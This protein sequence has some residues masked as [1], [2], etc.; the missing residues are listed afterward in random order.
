MYLHIQRTIRRCLVF[1]E[2]AIQFSTVIGQEGNVNLPSKIT[3]SE[4]TKTGVIVFSLEPGNYALVNAFPEITTNAFSYSERT[5]EVTVKDSSLLDYEGY[6]KSFVMRFEERITEG[7]PVGGDLVL[8]IELQDVQETSDSS[9][10]CSDVSTIKW[11][12]PVCSGIEL[13]TVIIWT[14]ILLVCLIKKK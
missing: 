9:S 7:N 12:V 8:L 14:T 10:C 2:F 3:V 5:G 1:I 11:L 4:N 13:L 6:H